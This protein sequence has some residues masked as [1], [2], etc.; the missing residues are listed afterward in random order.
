M[1]GDR[2]C[3]SGR[4]HPDSAGSRFVPPHWP[5]GSCGAR[6]RCSIRIED[7][8][9]DTADH[10]TGLILRWRGQ[11]LFAVEPVHRWRE[12]TDRSSA[13][14]PLVRFVGIGGH[15][16]AGESWRQAVL[17]EAR[18]EAGLEVSLVAPQATYL[19]GDDD[20]VIDVSAELDWP[21]SPR[22][23]FIW[24]AAQDLERPSP[25]H[26]VRLVTAAFSAVGPDDVEPR[27]LAEIP[28]IVAISDTQLR[29]AA[30]RPVCLRDLL[31]DGARIWES[32]PIPRSA[33]LVP[34]G[35][36][37]GYA[38]LLIHHASHARQSEV[39]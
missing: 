19:L 3:A 27:P 38:V 2:L 13:I 1:G 5:T 31:A 35:S 24:R 12:V 6:G 17:R 9:P 21:D 16:E 23:C 15:V 14:V 33:L 32:A 20:T 22:P 26:A 37:L 36:A 30:A 18:E 7:L 28:A 39:S 29:R 8:A 11:L 4:T 10:S 34:A 25:E